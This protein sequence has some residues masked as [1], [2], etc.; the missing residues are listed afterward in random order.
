MNKKNNNW[1]FKILTILFIIY[2]ALFIANQTGYYEKT[3][4]DKTFLT[5]EKM[6]EFEQDVA[7]NKVIDI[8]NYLPEKE[9]YSNFWT[10]SANKL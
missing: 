1:F 10:K 5:E 9:D 8:I 3:I 7:D 2:V 6:H 4:R